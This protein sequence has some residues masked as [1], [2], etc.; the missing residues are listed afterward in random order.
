MSDVVEVDAKESSKS[1]VNNILPGQKLKKA[2]ERRNLEQADIAKELK[3]DLRFVKALE[4]EEFNE[5][6]QPVFTAGYVRA[7]SKL[8]GL[9]PDEI[10]PEYSAHQSASVT[11]KSNKKEKEEI[12]SHYRQV[13]NSLPKSFSVGQAQSNDRRKL[14]ILISILAV[15]L[16]FAIVWQ[17]SDKPVETPTTGV[18]DQSDSDKA[19]TPPEGDGSMSSSELSNGDTSIIDTTEQSTVKLPLPKLQTPSTTSSTT[20][21]VTL[22]S[23]DESVSA[24]LAKNAQKITELSLHYTKDSWVDIRDATGKAIIRRLGLAGKSNTVTGVPPFEVLLGYSP[25]VSIEYD[26]KPYDLSAYSEKRVARFVLK[27]DGGVESSRSTAA[28]EKFMA[29]KIERSEPFTVVE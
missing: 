7:Y 15:V 3:L 29:P 21:G 26:G 12:P 1:D 9:K 23:G 18:E 5:L 11:K 13:D 20:E 17:V 10:V 2:R 4:E 6:P 14:N 16:V 24:E 28:G 27:S 19:S 25:G 8:V 22:A